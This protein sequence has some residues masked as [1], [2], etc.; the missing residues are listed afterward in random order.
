MALSL[1]AVG[2]LS[3]PLAKKAKTRT[4][5]AI[6]L[7]AESTDWHA[8]AFSGRR[9]REDEEVRGKEGVLREAMWMEMV[10]D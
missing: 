1:L 10:R 5:T 9:R 7:A 8:T 2:S 6:L 3:N 4:E